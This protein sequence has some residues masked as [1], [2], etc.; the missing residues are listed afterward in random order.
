MG[1]YVR[2]FTETFDFDGD[3]ITVTLKQLKRVDA[4]KLIPIMAGMQ[5]MNP[6]KPETMTDDKIAKSN[7][8]VN[9]A[10]S[11]IK[12]G[13]Y[14]ANL[15][16]MT[17]QNVPVTIDSELFNDI[18]DDFYFTGFVATIATLLIKHGSI[19]KPEEKKSGVQSNTTKEGLQEEEE[20]HL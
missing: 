2:N 6:E 14:I 9:V 7:E 1:N 13:G 19:S 20:T 12:E 15:Q 8:Y 16:G 17:V 5:G 11:I 18:F 4:M 10:A 3:S